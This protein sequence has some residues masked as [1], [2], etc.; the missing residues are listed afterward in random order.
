MDKRSAV[1]SE[2]R[3]QIDVQTHQTGGNES[4]GRGGALHSNRTQAIFAG[5]RIRSNVK[6]AEAQQ[7]LAFIQYEKTIQTA[8][9]EVSDAPVQYQR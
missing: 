8:F 6:L 9:R 3:Q 1:N 4:H 2:T 5:G 7:Q